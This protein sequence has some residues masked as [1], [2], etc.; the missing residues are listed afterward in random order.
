[1]VHFCDWSYEEGFGILWSSN[2]YQNDLSIATYTYPIFG[3]RQICIWSDHGT[4]RLGTRM[5]KE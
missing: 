1:M 4:E 5:Q 2:D 3:S